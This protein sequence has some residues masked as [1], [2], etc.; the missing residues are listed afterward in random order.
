MEQT[1]IEQVILTGGFKGDFKVDLYD[2]I[3]QVILKLCCFTESKN[4]QCLFNNK[5]NS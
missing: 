5:K 4:Y 3:E 2:F 1:N